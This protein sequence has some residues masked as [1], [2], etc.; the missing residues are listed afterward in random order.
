M[1]V[2]DVLVLGKGPAGLAAA[3]ALVEHGLDV[4][5]L[6]PSGPVRWPAEYGAWA[7]E[8]QALGT[9]DLAQYVWSETLVGL[10][11]SDQRVLNR[12]YVRIDKERL[13]ARLVDGCERGR[14][15]WVDGRA[16]AVRH[17]SSFS[18][19]LCDGGAEIRA[20]L[21]LDASGHRPALVRR[22]A[23]PAQGFQTAFGLVIDYEGQLFPAGRAVLMDWDDEW[24]PP[25]ERTAG[26]PSFLYAL[27]LGEGRLF[28]E[29]TVLV[30]RPAVPIELLE[31][32]LRRRLAALGVPVRAASG[33]E[34]C[35]IPMGGALPDLDQRTVG[36]GGA[37]GM[38]HPATGYLV[39]RVLERA[40]H[41][42]ATVARELGAPHADP[43][44]AARA[45]WHSLW[46]GDRRQRHAL[47]RFGMEVLLRLDP[48]RTRAFFAEFFRLPDADWQGYLGDRLSAAELRA[49]MLRL[50]RRL[51]LR[52]RASLIGAALD[53]PGLELAR[54]VIHRH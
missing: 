22:A 26:P 24:L 6:G 47:F 25:A 10:G 29:E 51:P 49:A 14:V 16:T 11:G 31:Q 50:F 13:A 28:V 27:P 34:R 12:A 9:P 35:W 7:D 40:P 33:E 21:V 44:R 36:F 53:R 41:L 54:N 46:P 4:A 17:C 2:F 18:A 43:G 1:P 3:A 20:R 15:R 42:A 45:A 5:V 37:A 39:G 23:A 19:V 8:L 48:P 30:G 32:R 52:L 38:V